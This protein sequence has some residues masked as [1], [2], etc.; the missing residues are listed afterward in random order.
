MTARLIGPTCAAAGCL[1]PP[2]L[3]GLC[4]A[5]HALKRAVGI[6][7]PQPPPQSPDPLEEELQR[8]LTDTP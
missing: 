5:H 2:Y 7:P 3:A 6:T 1:R 4:Y 8:W